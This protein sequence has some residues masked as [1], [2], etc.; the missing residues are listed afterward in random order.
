MERQMKMF[1]AMAMLVGAVIAS[2]ETLA[3]N[4]GE[5]TPP[6]PELPRNIEGADPEFAALLKRLSGKVYR[7]LLSNGPPWGAYK[8]VVY[9]NGTAMLSE[10]HRDKEAI[11]ACDGQFPATVSQENGWLVIAHTSAP[12][13]NEF[14]R[15]RIA[16]RPVGNTLITPDGRVY[17]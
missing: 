8:I 17:R 4:G 6:S 11:K 7:L 3:Q 1:F 12:R 14:C 13:G 9:P 10:S 2:A 15:N 5:G 16:V